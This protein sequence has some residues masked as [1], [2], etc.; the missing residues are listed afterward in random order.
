MGAEPRSPGGP[1]AHRANRIPGFLLIRA[2]TRSALEAFV[3]AF[4]RPRVWPSLTLQICFQLAGI[5]QRPSAE[6]AAL[7]MLRNNA[8]Q[9]RDEAARRRLPELPAA[10]EQTPAHD[11]RLRAL[12]GSRRKTSPVESQFPSS[13]KRF[14]LL[15]IKSFI[16]NLAREKGG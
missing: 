14:T 11:S 8:A 16:M 4:S 1:G 3:A 13:S 9:T 2:T 7:R 10:A 6:V 12:A 15:L 5:H